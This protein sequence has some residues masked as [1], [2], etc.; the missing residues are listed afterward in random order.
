MFNN[1]IDWHNETHWA[2]DKSLHIFMQEVML[3]NA[4]VQIV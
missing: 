1:Q 3:N 4:Q 2:I